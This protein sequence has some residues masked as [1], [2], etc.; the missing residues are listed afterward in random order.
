MVSAVGNA[1]LAYAHIPELSAASGNTLA[2]AAE[3]GHAA[4]LASRILA[5]LGG[6]T[7]R[8]RRNMVSVKRQLPLFPPPFVANKVCA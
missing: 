4:A 6:A 3:C 8:S 7:A 2:N 1:T 5:I